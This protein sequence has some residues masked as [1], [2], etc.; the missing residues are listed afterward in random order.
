MKWTAI[1]SG[2]LGLTM[3][4]A[5]SPGA[6]ACAT[7]FGRSDSELAAGMN[8]GILF[9]LAVI[10]GVLAGFASFF[11]YLARRASRTTLGSTT[12]GQVPVAE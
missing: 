12:A 2:A 3:S 6:W 5:V 4:G 9:L 1:F 10:L 8:S 7:C 11:V